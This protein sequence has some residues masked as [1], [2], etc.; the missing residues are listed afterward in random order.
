[1]SIFIRKHELECS[2]Q[3]YSKPTKW[4]LPQCLSIVIWINCGWQTTKYGVANYNNII[5]TPVMN[6][7][8][9]ILNNRDWT[10]PPPNSI[11]LHYYKIQ[12]K[13]T[14]KTKKTVTRCQ[15]SK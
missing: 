8:N 11:G 14:N 4:K 15:K 7:R 9:I 6:F 2:D 12:Q 1:M 10:P 5:I 3:H 13:Q